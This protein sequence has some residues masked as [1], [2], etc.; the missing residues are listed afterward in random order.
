[1]LLISRVLIQG[2]FRMLM[3][4]LAPIR[5]PVSRQPMRIPSPMKRFGMNLR[6]YGINQP[7][8]ELKCK[9]ITRPR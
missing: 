7:E 2:N 8:G 3:L 5:I 1:M 4:E 9:Q 6:R